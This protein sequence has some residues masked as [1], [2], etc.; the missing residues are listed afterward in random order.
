CVVGRREVYRLKSL[1]K[2]ADKEAFMVINDVHEVMGYG[3]R[4]RGSA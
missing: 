4:R 2:R 3:F 1:V